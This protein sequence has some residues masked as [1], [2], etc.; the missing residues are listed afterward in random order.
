MTSSGVY[1]RKR[2]LG[3]TKVRPPSGTEAGAENGGID[4]ATDG[5]DFIQSENEPLRRPLD[6]ILIHGKGDCLRRADENATPSGGP[7]SVSI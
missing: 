6:G 3:S 2:P 4:S 5:G 1:G 7:A